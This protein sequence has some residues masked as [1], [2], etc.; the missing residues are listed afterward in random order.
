MNL[1]RDLEGRKIGYRGPSMADWLEGMGAE[2][3]LY[4]LGDTF[5]TP[6]ERGILDCALADAWE[7]YSHRLYEVTDFLNGP[8]SGNF[9]F[10]SNVIGGDKWR[11]IPQDIQQIIIEE[12]AKSE[13]EALRL[14]AIQNET[15]LQRN[16]DGGLEFVSFSDEIKRQSFSVAIERVIPGWVQRAGGPRSPSIADTFNNKVGPIVGLRIRSDGTVVKT[17]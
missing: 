5:Y 3:Q 17:N 9:N 14:A 6:L 11:G 2:G 8:L 15:G 10:A 4:D 1:L 7:G 12:A 16:I 13:L